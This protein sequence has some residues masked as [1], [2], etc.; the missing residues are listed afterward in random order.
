MFS[1][2]EWLPTSAQRPWRPSTPNAVPPLGYPAEPRQFARPSE[3][4]IDQAGP[5]AARQVAQTEVILMS[6][7]SNIKPPSTVEEI[8]EWNAGREARVAKMKQENPALA[9]AMEAAREVCTEQRAELIATGILGANW[10]L[11]LSERDVS[12]IHARGREKG[13][14]GLRSAAELIDAAAAKVRQ[15]VA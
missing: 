12:I 6:D 5:P 7:Q 1:Q 2:L 11:A 14:S 4:G 13:V 3:V 8:Q 9:E 10:H 15:R